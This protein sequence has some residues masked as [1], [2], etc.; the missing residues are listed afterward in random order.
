MRNRTLVVVLAVL[1]C[2]AFAATAICVTAKPAAK[3]TTTA[4]KASS[5]AKPAPKPAAK[6]TAKPAAKP[7]PKPAAKPAATKPFNQDEVLDKYWKAPNSAIVG[8]VDGASVTK[9]ELMEALFYWNGPQVLSDLLNQKMIEQAAKKAG[10]TITPAE[11]K[12]KEMEAVK[13][14]QLKSVDE[15]LKQFHVSRKRFTSSIRISALA[16]KIVTRSIKLSDADYAEWIKARHILIRFP[17]TETDQT[18][19]EEAAKKKIDEIAAKLK[20]GEDFAKLA[21]EYSEDPSNTGENGVKKGGDLGWFTKG[22]MVQEFEKAAFDLKVGQVSEPVKTFYGYHLIK[23]DALGKDTTGAEREE[24]KKMIME[25]KLPMEMQ[26]WFSELQAKAKIDN[27][28][29]E[30]APKPPTVQ[31][32][33]QPKPAPSKPAPAP[34]PKPQETKPAETKPASTPSNETPPPPPAN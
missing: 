9:G 28:L 1:I 34:S 24:L 33:P 23:V 11:Q 25:R 8:T 30:P 26:R 12:E 32:K 21:D 7:A 5:A 3:S 29:Q 14:M 22:R 4:A 16:E 18:K 17:E 2:L 19:K 27:K 20:A 6:P 31:P 10:I 13:R 15:L